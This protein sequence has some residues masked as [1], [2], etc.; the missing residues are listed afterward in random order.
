MTE[1][2]ATQVD[3]TM[4]Q[5]SVLLFFT[6]QVCFI[7]FRTNI[8]DKSGIFKFETRPP[9]KCIQEYSRQWSVKRY[10]INNSL[11]PN[12]W[13]TLFSQ[14][15]YYQ[16]SFLGLSSTI[17]SS[18]EP[19]TYHSRN[20]FHPTT[21]SDH[22][23]LSNTYVQ[24]RSGPICGE[25]SSKIEIFS[26]LLGKTARLTSKR[27]NW[28]K[29]LRQKTENQNIM[30]HTQQKSSNHRPNIDSFSW[31]TPRTLNA[32]SLLCLIPASGTQTHFGTDL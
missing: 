32:V 22:I 17:S 3:L 4:S 20:V 28:W 2:R 18:T 30:K 15:C 23:L 6:G 26:E 7:S 24:H 12:K 8:L 5:K 21:V 14:S 1:H 9:N 16:K 19:E 25:S 27:D 13:W 29:T 10:Q 31:N 11:L